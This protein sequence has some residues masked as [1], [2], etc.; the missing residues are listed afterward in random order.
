MDQ[1]PGSVEI[2][3]VFLESFELL[4]KNPHAEGQLSPQDTTK[5]AAC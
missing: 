4:R 1:R 5:D 3:F 2:L